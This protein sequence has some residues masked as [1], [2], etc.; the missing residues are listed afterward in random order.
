LS[1][2]PGRGLRVFAAD[3]DRAALEDLSGLL[4]S[5]GHDVLAHAVGVREAAEKIASD[6][7]DIAMVV[8]HD[9]DEHALDLIEEIVEYGSGPVI[10]LLEREDPDFVARAADRGIAAYARPISAESVQ[11]AIE[12][13]IRRHAE[14]E[15]LS[16]KVS[17]L[18]T[19]LARRAV[20]ERAK[21][22]LMERHSV[23]E[24]AAFELL[25]MHARSQNRT[26]VAVAQAVCDGRALLPSAD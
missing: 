22:I 17:Q 16:D 19:A 10:A 14:T 1:E 8:L 6:E 23:D 12:V 11:G 9:D 25:R 20:I 13:A 15:A 3:E 26:V 7:P 2:D 21:G 24:R 18:E 5:L 4:D